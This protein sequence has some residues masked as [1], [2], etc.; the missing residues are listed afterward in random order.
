MTGEFDRKI[1]KYQKA[2]HRKTIWYRVLGILAAVTIF[3]TTYALILPAITKEP[4]PGIKLERDFIHETDEVTI[5]FNVVGRAVFEN[6]DVDF[7]D[8]SG[9][10]VELTVTPLDEESMVFSQYQKYAD[11]NIGSDD[12]YKL[13]AVRLIFTYQ[14]EKLDME[15]CVITANITSK[16]ELFQIGDGNLVSGDV[17][18]GS[19]SVGLWNG[20]NSIDPVTGI[21]REEVLA[22][23]AIQGVAIDMAEQDTAYLAEGEDTISLSTTLSSNSDTM[24]FA[25]YSTINPKYTVQ[26]YSHITVFDDDGDVS[27]DVIDTS[28]GVLPINGKTPATIPAY[29]NYDKTAGAYVMAMHQELAP[30]YSSKEYEY[31]SAPGVAYVDR[32]REN[33]NFTLGEVWVLKAGK[34]PTSIK[35]TDW[36]IYPSTVSF[37]NRAASAN[38]NRIYI[39]EDT[40]IRLVYNE[41][42]GSYTSGANFYDYDITDGDIHNANGKVYSTNNQNNNLWLAQT[43]YQGINNNK[44]Y[45]G[46]GT[47]LAFGNVNTGTGL[48]TLQWKDKNGVTNVPNQYNRVNGT[49]VGFDGCT[50]GLVTGMND[51][52]TLIYA[53][54]I[55]APKLFGYDEAVGK[56]MLH[57][58]SLQFNRTGDTYVLTSINGTG[59]KNLQYFTNPTYKASNG[60]T[61]LHSHIFTNNFWPMDYSP[62]YGAAGHDLKFGNALL[63]GNRRLF[64]TTDTF[65]TQ[66]NFPVSD[67][68]VDH[69]SYF[70]MNYEVEFTLTEDYLGHLEYIFY[71]DDDMWVF[72]D[73]KLVCDIGGVHSSVGQYVNLW[74][75]INK[76]PDDQKYGKH[77]LSFY[78]TERGASGSTC[79]MQFTLP[80]V[81]VDTPQV[82]NN[83]LEVGK[84]VENSDTN[85]DFE[86]V[87][88]L[89]DK[90]GNNLVD[91]Y[92]YTLHDKDGTALE[93]SIINSEAKV[94]YLK[95][96]QYIEINYLP[97]GVR[98]RI[99]EKAYD[100]FHTTYVIGNGSV[101]EGYTAEGELTEDTR[102]QFTNSTGMVLPS[103]GGI[104]MWIFAIPFIL[105]IGVGVLIPFIEKKRKNSTKN[106]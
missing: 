47:K 71:G 15:N 46:S 33:G 77:T 49:T 79:Y 86:F 26:Y 43:Q 68:G 83:T 101:V 75:Y 30:L 18:L 90:N 7:Q 31:I 36:D 17:V 69:N 20:S 57:G 2:H 88:E 58:Y 32:N 4:S 13:L 28:G 78:Y 100:G 11:S 91:D 66:R 12:L 8:L 97:P 74:D 54:G 41:I 3:V 22:F 106:N 59:T 67:D 37:T 51:D 34:S 50:F 92:S 21:V 35:S 25:L 70:G 72:L 19:G 85:M 73:G 61:V 16:S 60:S 42:G 80:S 27:I 14:G 99:T 95:N 104:G 62:T 96:G 45:S 94:V 6:E 1:E 53:N 87:I 9:D 10:N 48:G 82:E 84:T 39:S 103:T 81:S 44:N 89:L 29:L 23:S 52:Q 105:A 56:T 102:V 65:N 38:S 24:A 5:S 64:A 98:Y 40:V 93:T 76:L 63:L 55:V